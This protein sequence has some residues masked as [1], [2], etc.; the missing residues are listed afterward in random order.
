MTNERNYDTTTM[1]DGYV[2]DQLQ[3]FDEVIELHKKFDAAE[4]DPPDYYPDE[5]DAYLDFEKLENA[6]IFRNYELLRHDY[7]QSWVEYASTVIG[8]GTYYTVS[9]FLSGEAHI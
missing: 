9:E 5:L 7:T 1:S 8:I 6:W 3:S 4:L 2:I